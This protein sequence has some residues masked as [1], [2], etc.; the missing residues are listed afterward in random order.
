MTPAISV[1]IGLY[2]K[3]PYIAR[4]A[5]SVFAQ[6]FSNFELIVVDDGSTDGG[7]EELDR[8]YPDSRFRLICQSNAGNGAARNAG[9]R[10]SRAPII[11]FLDADDEFLPTHLEGLF[12]LAKEYPTAGL[13]AAGYYA[14]SPDGSKLPRVIPR[15]DPLLIEDYFATACR[16]GYFL[17]PS[18]CAVRR[19]VIAKVGGFRE[20][21]PI[22]EDL[23]FWA[24]VALRFPVAYQPRPSTL[25]YVGVPG[26]AMHGFRWNPNTP[27]VVEMLSRELASEEPL[28]REQSIID[29][30]AWILLNHAATGIAVFQGQRSKQ[31]L[32]HPLI[33][34][35][36]LGLRRARLWLAATFFPRFALRGYLRFRE[37]WMIRARMREA[38]VWTTG[39]SLLKAGA[40]VTDV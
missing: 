37:W 36:R 38:R 14:A 6:T 2:N 12:A 35:S 25:Y 13:L 1:V 4:A 21:V 31:V 10:A 3:R 9:I 24:R 19:D 15:K 30:A 40:A 39:R 26:G 18:G 34:K 8:F 5:G 11:A 32:R 20:G 29:Y 23:E 16:H 22:G 7:A 27:A 33:A 28:D 17:T